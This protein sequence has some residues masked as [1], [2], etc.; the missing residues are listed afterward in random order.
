VNKEHPHDF[1]VLVP[2]DV[3]VVPVK[4]DRISYKNG[5]NF[6]R[7]WEIFNNSTQTIDSILMEVIGGDACSIF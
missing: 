7:Q 3:H 5:D 1:H 6:I 2:F 4:P